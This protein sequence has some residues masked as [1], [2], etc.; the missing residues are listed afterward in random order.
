MQHLQLDGHARELSRPDL[1]VQE[2]SQARLKVQAAARA[3]LQ[4]AVT[5]QSTL[6]VRQ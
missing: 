2:P 1:V 3:G 4:Q 5:S 6:R